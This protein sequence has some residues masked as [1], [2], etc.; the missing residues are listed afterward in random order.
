MVSKETKLENE[1][2]Q[3]KK[4]FCPKWSLKPQFQC[5]STWF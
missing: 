5:D 2:T 4:L 1:L 3:K